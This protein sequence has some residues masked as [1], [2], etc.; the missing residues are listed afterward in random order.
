MKIRRNM[1]LNLPE[2]D[3]HE[4]D[5]HGLKPTDNISLQFESGVKVD[6]DPSKISMT[7]EQREILDKL[8]LKLQEQPVVPECTAEGCPAQKVLSQADFE[9]IR[10]LNMTLGLGGAHAASGP[11]VDFCL[12]VINVHEA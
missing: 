12:H 9:K 8:V 6:I 10:N 7:E 4:I 2:G 5:L 3:T 1:V 11:I